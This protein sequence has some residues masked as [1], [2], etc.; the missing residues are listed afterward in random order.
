M[1]RGFAR[2]DIAAADAKYRSSA[3]SRLA[4]SRPHPK[5]PTSKLTYWDYLEW[6]SEHL[7]S[8]A[9]LKAIKSLW[10]EVG[11]EPEPLYKQLACAA[12]RSPD[13]GIPQHNR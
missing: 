11:G 5:L 13:W 12:Y 10:D 8:D 7:Y 6:L 4:L 3:V 1:Q 9:Y 2:S